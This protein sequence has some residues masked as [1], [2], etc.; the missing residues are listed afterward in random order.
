MK[1]KKLFL[2]I[3]IIVIVLGAV[4]AAVIWNA[5]KPDE[6]APEVLQPEVFED[7]VYDTDMIIGL[8]QLGTV[9]YRYNEDGTGVTW[10]TA[11][12]IMESEGSKFTW[13][14]NKNRFIHY[15]KMEISDGLI[16]KAYTITNLDLMNLEYVD[17]YKNI[18]AFT[19]VE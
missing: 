17:D 13:E 11:D 8:W 15:H 2:I 4:V 1:K 9:Y 18:S 10:D 3:L 12:D 7:D 19:K 16:P 14:V 6:Y 5:N